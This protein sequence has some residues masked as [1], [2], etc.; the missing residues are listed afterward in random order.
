MEW[1]VT[2]ASTVPEAKER[3]LDELGIDDAEAE[4]EVLETPEP[5]LFGRMRGEARVRARVVPR[6]PRPKI[7]RRER[8]GKSKRSSGRGSRKGKSTA[9]HKAKAGEIGAPSAKTDAAAEG[10]GA[11]ATSSRPAKKTRAAASAPATTDES[12]EA[13]M[14]RDHDPSTV[15]AK[16]S[17]T[18]KGATVSDITLSEQAEATADFLRGLL[19]AFDFDGDVDIRPIDDENTE[20]VVDGSDLGLLIGPR[21]QTLQAIGELSRA[22]SAQTLSGRAAGRVHLD[23]AQY[24]EKRR[25][26]LAE[27]TQKIAAEV[28][29]SDTAKALEPMAAADRKV[30]HDTCNDID[31][32]STISEGEDPRRRVVI[33]PAS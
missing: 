12:T 10:T 20:V 18:D 15:E 19:D 28:I 21:G 3:A 32:V 25:N 26:A 27:F 16:A 13:T 6:T 5:G 4:F 23:I 11:K 30:V 9:K 24:R 7:E 2:T 1:V 8:R 33:E 17:T 29:E 14:P 31:G 22:A